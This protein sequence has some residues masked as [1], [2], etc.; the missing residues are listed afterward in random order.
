MGKLQCIHF[1]FQIQKKGKT[2]VF[3]SHVATNLKE[4]QFVLSITLHN[5]LHLKKKKTKQNTA[6]LNCG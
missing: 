1:E 2:Y 3:H 6:L 4:L 5:R